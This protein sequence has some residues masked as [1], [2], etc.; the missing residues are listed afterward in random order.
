MREEERRVKGAGMGRI[1]KW[2]RK[3]R[4]TYVQCRTVEGNPQA[5]RHTIGQADNPEC[6]R[7]GKYAETGR[8]VALVRTHGEH[9]GRKWGT[10]EDMDDRARWAKKEKDEKGFYTVDLVETFFSEI[11]LR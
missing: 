5:W 4:V 9:R 3:A 11:D 10:W 2:S 1:M 6:R 7:C 8:H